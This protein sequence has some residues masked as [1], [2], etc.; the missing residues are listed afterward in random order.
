MSWEERSGWGFS[1]SR[2]GFVPGPKLC[3]LFYFHFSSNKMVIF[4]PLYIRGNGLIPLIQS[5]WASW[6][7]INASCLLASHVDREHYF[8]LAEF[9]L[10]WE[11]II[12]GIIIW[13]GRQVEYT[14]QFSITN[15][16]PCKCPWV[17]FFLK[18]NPMSSPIPVSSYKLKGM[19]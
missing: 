9:N 13:R 5:V 15:W 2:D 3:F 11:E 16:V 7:I 17:E 19:S 12:V 18:R 10:S 6:S 8:D 14:A 4:L 1:A